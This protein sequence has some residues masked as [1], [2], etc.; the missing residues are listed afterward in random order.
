LLHKTG[1]AAAPGLFLTGVAV[2]AL[3]AGLGLKRFGGQIGR[4]SEKR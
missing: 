3:A 4:A 2:I 1:S